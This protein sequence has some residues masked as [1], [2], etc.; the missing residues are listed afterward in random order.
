MM[1]AA[2]AVASIAFLLFVYLAVVATLGVSE[3]RR[4]T[5]L[6]DKD[7]GEAYLQAIRSQRTP[8]PFRREKPKVPVENPGRPVQVPQFKNLEEMAPDE[9]YEAISSFGESKP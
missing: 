6:M 3:L 7:S 9:A 1:G 4:L 5:T 8:V 2:L